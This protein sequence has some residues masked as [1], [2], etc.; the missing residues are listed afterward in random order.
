MTW[1][2][3]ILFFASSDLCLRCFY[4]IFVYLLSH[5]STFISATLSSRPVPF[6]MVFLL[7]FSPINLTV[8]QLS[9][10]CQC[11]KQEHLQSL[12]A[13]DMSAEIETA[14][15]IIQFDVTSIV[16]QLRNR[17]DRRLCV[18]ESPDNMY[19]SSSSILHVHELLRVFSPQ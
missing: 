2:L 17:D 4:N 18:P 9:C 3:Q 11:D 10:H 5:S 7:P 14:C 6:D 8:V 13:L 16:V 1:L 19:A 12:K 15:M